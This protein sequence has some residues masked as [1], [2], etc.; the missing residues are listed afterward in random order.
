M[1]G[2]IC[3]DRFMLRPH[4]DRFMLQPHNLA[5][6]KNELLEKLNTDILMMGPN[7]TQLKC[8]LEK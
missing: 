3:S 4:T 1:A 6:L 8:S 5:V 7:A 2:E